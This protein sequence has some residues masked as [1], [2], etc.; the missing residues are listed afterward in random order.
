M[1]CA[2]R[3]CDYGLYAHA[4]GRPKFASVFEKRIPT[5][6][7]GGSA[8]CAPYQDNPAFVALDYH[9]PTGSSGIGELPGGN[10]MVTLGL[11]DALTGRGTTYSQGATTFHELGHN[12]NLW[13]G[14]V[15]AILGQKKVGLGAPGTA[16]FVEPNCKPNHQSTMSYMFQVHGLATATGAAVLDYSDTLLGNLN[17]ATGLADGKFSVIPKYRPSWFAP[18]NSTLATT[19]GASAATRLCNGVKFN[20][21]D[22]PSPP[23]PAMARVWVSSPST[24]NPPDWD[25]P[26]NWNGDGDV[27]DTGTNLNVNFDGVFG[28]TQTLGVLNQVNDWANIRLDQIGAG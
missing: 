9:V 25:V 24:S 16:T 10:F 1:L 5:G 27:S 19:L 18:A 21:L 3:S 2:H 17:E 7:P 13:H 22:P 20:E 26:I 11:W 28:S 23:T 6:Y 8:P 12:L 15:P 4:R 14:G